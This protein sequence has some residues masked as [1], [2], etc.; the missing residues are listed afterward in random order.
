MI[1]FCNLILF[2][3]FFL[4]KF[5]YIPPFKIIYL[6]YIRKF[7]YQI[8]FYELIYICLC[9]FMYASA[10]I[11]TKVNLNCKGSPLNY[12]HVFILITVT[13]LC[14]TT[15]PRTNWYYFFNCFITNYHR[16]NNNYLF[17]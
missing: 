14:G 12:E 1:F 11:N 16:L 4:T 2:I 9:V 8:Y 17:V 10:Y 6:F 7:N 13:S 15:L 3:Y 5:I